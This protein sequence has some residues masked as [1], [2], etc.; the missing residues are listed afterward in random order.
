MRTLCRKTIKKGT[1]NSPMN[2]GQG[3]EV[4]KT[5]FYREKRHNGGRISGD[6]R[7]G[8]PQYAVSAGIRAWRQSL[9]EMQ[10]DAVPHG[11]RRQ[12]Q[13]VLSGVSER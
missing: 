2:G 1:P 11:D 13:R 9:S 8:L 3:V 5:L 4:S 10:G 7:K 6:K 12:E